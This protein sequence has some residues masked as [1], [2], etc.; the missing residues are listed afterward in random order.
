MA[1]VHFLHAH[2][3]LYGTYGQTYSPASCKV[4]LQLNSV[5]TLIL[6]LATRPPTSQELPNLSEA[7]ESKVGGKNTIPPASY[8][9][10]LYSGKVLELFAGDLFKLDGQMCKGAF[11]G[12][13]FCEVS[14]DAIYI[15]YA[16][17]R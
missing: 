10:R 9:F 15:I 12:D 1:C 2:N 16:Y 17:V 5:L 7:R 13:D 14:A 6:A 4:R 11:T 3:K 8:K